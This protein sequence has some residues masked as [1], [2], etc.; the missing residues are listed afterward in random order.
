MD[1]SIHNQA[2]QTCRR[3][4]SQ[5]NRDPSTA[6]YGCFDRRYW[7]WKIV[8]FPEATYQRNISPLCWFMDQPESIN[9]ERISEAVKSG[10]LYAIK[11]QNRDG[12]FNQAYPYEHSYGATAFLLSDLITAF[13][14]IEG[15]FNQEETLFVLN[16]LKQSANFLCKADEL[17]G[18]ISNHLAG[19]ALALLKAYQL[20]GDEKFKDKYKKV[21]AIIL[22]HQ[23]NEGWFPEYG[24][25][26]PGYQT[27]CMNYLAQIFHANPSISL[28]TTIEKSLEFLQYFIHPD[29][30]FG[31]EYGS[32]RTEI[33]YP[34]G[35]ALLTPDFPIA[36]EMHAFMSESIRAGNTV[37]LMDIDIGNTAPLLSSYILTEVQENIQIKRKKLPLMKP[38]INKFFRNSGIA[39]KGTEEYYAVIGTSNGGVL[40]VFDKKLKTII[41]DDCGLLGKAK[42]GKIFSNQI[43]N[44]NNPVKWAE[45]AIECS[46]GFSYLSSQVPT[47]INYLILRIANLSI[48]R[49]KFLNELVKK[50]LIKHLIRTNSPVPLKRFR[51]IKFER[52]RIIVTDRI[53]KSKLFQVAELTQGEK[54]TA[55]HMASARY[56]SPSQFAKTRSTHLNCELLAKSG[57]TTQSITIDLNKKARVQQK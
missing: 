11:I 14:K 34:G 2:I 56:F 55:I 30:S 42:N 39:I 36:A 49:I 17:H 28:R 8:D 57:I 15:T 21:L 32:R 3:L 4:L 18:F 24:G 48:M 44:L 27:L 41:Y 33:Y 19:A 40:K 52:D 35:I 38:D 31:G 7:A 5:I 22:H 13:Q 43:T 6:T 51:R 12:S 47:P 54:F 9:S 37:T 46:S 20:F 1:I 29:G 45:N 10:L 50:A 53:E 16:K 25:A 23:S 26:D